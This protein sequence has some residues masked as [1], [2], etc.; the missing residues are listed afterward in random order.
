MQT[1]VGVKTGVGAD[2]AARLFRLLSLHAGRVCLHMYACFITHLTIFMSDLDSDKNFR[3]LVAL[4][5][6]NIKCS[7][8]REKAHRDHTAVK[9][10]LLSVLM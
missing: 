10:M 3:P 5:K 8:S 1:R 7:E 6:L 2:G 4:D 9:S